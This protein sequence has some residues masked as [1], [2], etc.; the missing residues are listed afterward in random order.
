M[1]ILKKSKKRKK[2]LMRSRNFNKMRILD[3]HIS[4]SAQWMPLN[5]CKDHTRDEAHACVTVSEIVVINAV[6]M[7]FKRLTRRISSKNG[8]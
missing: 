5:S 2:L 1:S 4:R 3:M 6:L 7:H 8:H